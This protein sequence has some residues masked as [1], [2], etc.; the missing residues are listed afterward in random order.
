MPNIDLFNQINT[1]LKNKGISASRASVQA[2]LGI[3]FIR[4]L[5]RRQSRP[6]LENLQK[7]ANYLD[8]D[9]NIFL[10]ILDENI[11]MRDT[12]TSNS[13]FSTIYIIGQIQAGQWT[14]ATEWPKEDWIP[15]PFPMDTQYKDF[16]TFALKVKGDS[17]N[18]LYP[19]GSIVIAINFCDLGRNPENGECV[20]TIRRDP[21]TDCYE[22]TLKVVQI[23]DDGSVLLWPRSD[24][25]DFTKPIQLPKITTRYQG[26]GMDG[27]S[28]SAPDILIQSLVIWS[29][30]VASKV[31]L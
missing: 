25:P 10:K 9:I 12:P 5:K 11:V 13:F 21:L 16:P 29:F 14:Q 1:I 8:I 2:G 22:A 18:L 27:D 17:M 4:D 26:N 7:L 23:R 24:N 3:D 6:K 15:F 20:V 31:T 28:S 30:N 19:E